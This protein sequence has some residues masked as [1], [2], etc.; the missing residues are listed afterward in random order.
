MDIRIAPM[1]GDEITEALPALARLRI[2]VFKE[3]PYLYEGT[4]EYEQTYLKR[5]SAARDAIIVAAFDGAQIVGV[6]TASPLLA[7]TKE[8]APLFAARELDPEAVFYCGESV[9]LPPYRGRGIGHA[10]FDHREAHARNCS[11]ATGAF[12]HTAFC[13]VVRAP[14][15]PRKPDGYIPLDGFWR[16]RGYAPAPGLRGSYSWR[17]IGAEPETAKPMQFWLRPLEPVIT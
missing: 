14:Q 6:A 5:F 13:G 2:E 3:W 15:D 10:F 4:L 16:K 12:T 8:F 9:L 17:E 7:H 1:T 11:N